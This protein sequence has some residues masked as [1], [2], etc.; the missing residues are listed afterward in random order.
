MNMASQDI[1][2]Y[3]WSNVSMIAPASVYV[4]QNISINC[5]VADAN[6]TTGIANYQVKVYNSTTKVHEGPANATG[7]V[8]YTWATDSSQTGTYTFNC[9]IVHNGT[10][11]Y[12]TSV[13]TVSKQIF[14]NR[15]VMINLTEGNGTT[16]GTGNPVNITI[17]FYDLGKRIYPQ[18]VSGKIWVEKYSGLYGDF[19]CNS[20]SSGN[21]TITLPT[22]QCEAGR[23]IYIKDTDGSTTSY[24]IIVNTGGSETIDGE[25]S[26]T[27]DGSLLRQSVCLYSDGSNW[28]ILNDYRGTA[29]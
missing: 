17:T 8:N 19:D 22:A 24:D 2:I 6:S 3:G 9:T 18:G 21:C 4:G 14:A 29:V 10:L 23:I 25:A 26:L 27:I 16:V 13:S 20:T 28:F 15:S 12:N 1:F 7:V 5:T 11:Y